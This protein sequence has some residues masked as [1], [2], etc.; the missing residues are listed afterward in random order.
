M[1]LCVYCGASGTVDARYLALATDLGGRI[2]TRGDTLVYG[3]A[4][5]GLMGALAR[6][7]HA[8]GGRVIGIIPQALVDKEVS[9]TACDEMITT[10]DLRERKGMMDARSDAFLALPGGLGTLEEITEIMSQRA[11]K[12]SDKPL[13]LLDLEGYYQPLVTLFD[14]MAAM[15]FLRANHGQ[16]YYTAPDLDAAFAYLDSGAGREVD[17]RYS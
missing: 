9:Y 13:I 5:V 11:L 1:N 8:A 7:V 16:L 3:G 15:G 17:G 14:H 4:S 10:R 6:G 12:I 2:A